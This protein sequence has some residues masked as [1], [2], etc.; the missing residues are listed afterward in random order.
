MNFTVL[1]FDS[2]DSTNTEALKHARLGADEGLCIAAR[3]QTAGRGRRGRNWVSPR[4][5]GF[6]LSIV[7]RPQL[8]PETLPLITLATAIAVHDTLAEIGL[9]PDIKWP[10]DIL[11]GE[12][13]ICGILAE[14]TE[15]KEGLAIIVGIGINL[16]SKRFPDDIAQSATSIEAETGRAMKFSTLETFLEQPL[17]K[18]VAYWYERLLEPGGAA[19][20]RDEWASRSTYFSGKQVRVTLSNESFTGVTDGLEP[21]GALRIK[22]D[23]SQLAIVQAGDVEKLRTDLD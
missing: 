1:R 20:V 22:R 17:L 5:A 12:K 10:N 8:D 3:Q 21:N 7:L 18:L 6:Y 16:T 23:D 4:D 2:I 13:K 15:T 11:V 9:K 19:V 14:T